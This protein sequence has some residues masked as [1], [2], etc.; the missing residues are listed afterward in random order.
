M[1]LRHVSNGGCNGEFCVL[2]RTWAA[3]KAILAPLSSEHLQVASVLV[4]EFH[5][6]SYFLMAIAV[7]SDESTQR[8]HFST[9]N[10]SVVGDIEKRGDVISIFLVGTILYKSD[11]GDRERGENRMN[12]KNE[13]R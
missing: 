7:C 13:R 4:L 8:H 11:R 12:E 9:H 3:W 2:L 10:N 5:T 6:S 1:T